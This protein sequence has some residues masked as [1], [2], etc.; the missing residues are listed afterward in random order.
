GP[1]AA[2]QSQL[3]LLHL[4]P[5]LKA[6]R[7]ELLG[8]GG[9]DE[10]DAD[11]LA[12]RHVALLVARVARQ[13]LVRT[14]LGRVDEDARRADVGAA[15]PLA[16]EREVAFVEV[17]HGGNQGER[18]SLSLQLG[19]PG[20]YLGGGSEDVGHDSRAWAA[21]QRRAGSGRDARNPARPAPRKRVLDRD[22]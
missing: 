12:L 18:L 6:G 16:H 2:A 20:A 19:D 21:G 22:A 8:R 17:A 7:I 4:D 3:Q 5:G 9:E 11:G 13:I 10:R 1:G 14:E 15:Q